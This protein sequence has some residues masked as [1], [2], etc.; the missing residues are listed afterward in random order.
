MAVAEA[1]AERETQQDLNVT[2]SLKEA[3]AP[4]LA[5][6]AAAT[7]GNDCLME[8]DPEETSNLCSECGVCERCEACSQ[9]EP[10]FE[11]VR[12]GVYNLA[13]LLKKQRLKLGKGWIEQVSML[14]F[15]LGDF[16]HKCGDVPEACVAHLTELQLCLM[17]SAPGRHP[18]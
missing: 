11:G 15:L 9:L 4:L 17:R 16:G 8:A 3:Q 1:A 13:A 12:D 6:E 2:K 18:G 14:E 5:D 10:L 7:Q